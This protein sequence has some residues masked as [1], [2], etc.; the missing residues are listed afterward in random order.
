[1]R[2][3]FFLTS[4]V[5]KA[6][7]FAVRPSWFINPLSVTRL[8]NTVAVCVCD[9]GDL[10]LVDVGWSAAQCED[11]ARVLGRARAASL[12][13]VVTSED[14]LLMQ[15]RRLGFSADRVKAIIATHLHLD[16]VGG[17]E[18]FPNAEVICA[19]RELRSYAHFDPAYRAADLARAGRLRPLPLEGI[20]GFDDAVD[21]FGDGFLRLFG[22]FGHSRG[23]LAVII[24]APTWLFVHIGDA[25]Y[26]TWEYAQPGTSILA[27]FTAWRRSD[28]E[29]GHQRLRALQAD[30]CSPMLVPSHD[31]D[32]FHG[33]PQVPST[34]LSEAP[35]S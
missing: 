20:Q 17:V 14:S 28:L 1:M 24:D 31:L 10:V 22:L 6:P 5:M 26:Q 15:L 29:H 18:D 16:H 30:A 21:P 2:D 34:L 35:R 27:R 32:V 9:D 23:S 3:V 33:L 7:T 12:G 13:L 8:A 4:G 11:P 25:V 19:D